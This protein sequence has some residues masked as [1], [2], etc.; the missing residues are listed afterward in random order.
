MCRILIERL[1][2]SCQT[3]HDPYTTPLAIHAE[4][5]RR[6]SGDCCVF[7]YRPGGTATGIDAGTREA[8]EAEEAEG[9]FRQKERKLESDYEQPCGNRQTKPS[10]KLH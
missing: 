5:G 1:Y 3:P 8:E 10:A 6:N 4:A 7:T 2:C 9:I